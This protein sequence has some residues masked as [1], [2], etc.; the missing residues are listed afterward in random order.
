MTYFLGGTIAEKIGRK[1]KIAYFK[2]FDFYS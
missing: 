2:I 1:R